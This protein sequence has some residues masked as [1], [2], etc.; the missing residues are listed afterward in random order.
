MDVK[1]EV[2]ERARF[3][4]VS[5]GVRY[6]EDAA[7]K[8]LRD[9]GESPAELS[10]EEVPF[11]KG[12]CWEPVIDLQTGQVLGW[13]EG[14]EARIHYKVCDAGQYWLLDDNKQRIAQWKGYYVPDDILCVGRSGYGD[15]IIFTIGG[16]GFIQHWRNPGIDPEEWNPF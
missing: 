11:R 12:D 9:T 15:Y 2:T 16:D 5:A 6:W 10:F 3:I 7:L 1:L 13:P 14:V 8:N 4:E